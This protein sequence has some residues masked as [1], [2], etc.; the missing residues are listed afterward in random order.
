MLLA[1][2]LVWTVVALALHAL[3][4]SPA[5]HQAPLNWHAVNDVERRHAAGEINRD[6]LLRRR[7]EL[8]GNQ[9]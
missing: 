6:E 4:A 8:R 1:V 2:I 7:G 3:L 5:T 9:A